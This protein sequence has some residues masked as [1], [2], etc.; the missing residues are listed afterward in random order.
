MAIRERLEFPDRHIEVDHRLA[1]M[2]GTLE[3]LYAPD[4]F[5]VHL[6]RD[7]DLTAKSFARR[8]MNRGISDAFREILDAPRD[9]RLKFE[10]CESLVTVVED[11]IEAF[12]A[13]PSRKARSMTIDVERFEHGFRELCQRI[14]AEVDLEAACEKLKIK[15]SMTTQRWLR[16]NERKQPKSRRRGGTGRLRKPKRGSGR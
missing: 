8:M 9:L 13:E 2:P 11:N 10:L 15:F 4:V 1:W 16:R 7:R 3:R 6:R 14:G 5:W 12:L